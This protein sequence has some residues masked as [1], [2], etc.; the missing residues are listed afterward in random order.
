MRENIC[1]LNKP[2]TRNSDAVFELD[3]E[4]V[5]ALGW[6][7]EDVGEVELVSEDDLELRVNLLD[8]GGIPL[9]F[10]SEIELGLVGHVVSKLVESSPADGEWLSEELLSVTLGVIVHFD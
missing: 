4:V 6:V 10:F 5:L 9:D 1:L 8:V 3:A 7:C 2:R